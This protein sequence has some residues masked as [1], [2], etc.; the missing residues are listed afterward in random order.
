MCVVSMVSD[1]YLHKYKQD[2]PWIND[3]IYPKTDY[4][5]PNTTTDNRVMK[6]VTLLPNPPAIPDT[7]SREEFDAL[8]KEVEDLK[9]LLQKSIEYDKNNNEPECYIDDKVELLKNL[10]KAM[11][12]DIESVFKK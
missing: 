8:K 6:T 9:I 1:H 11:G 10:G 4:Y 7:V 5:P 3:V 12:V 2:Y